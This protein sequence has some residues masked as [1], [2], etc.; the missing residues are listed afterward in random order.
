MK[1]SIFL[2]LFLFCVINSYS[3]D[4]IILYKGKTIKGTIKHIED[5]KVTI[6]KK[7]KELVFTPDEVQYIEFDALNLTFQR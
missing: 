1:Y 4:K 7:K 6:K 2:F 3:K 5:N